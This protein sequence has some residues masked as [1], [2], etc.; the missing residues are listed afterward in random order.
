MSQFAEDSTLF[1]ADEHSATAAVEPLTQF[2]KAP[3][4]SLNISKTKVMW[5]GPMKNSKHTACDI[6]PSSEQIHV[7]G[8]GTVLQVIL[9][10]ITLVQFNKI[11]KRSLAP[12]TT[13]P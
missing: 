8:N 1:A 5:L 13:E 12:G 7:P 4:L 6:T 10:L 2:E 3:D 11:F 9:Q